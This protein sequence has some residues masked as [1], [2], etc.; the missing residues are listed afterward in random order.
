[1]VSRCI[2]RIRGCSSCCSEG[3]RSIEV[4]ISLWQGV[5]DR[6][7]RLSLVVVEERERRVERRCVDDLLFQEDDGDYF[8]R[9]L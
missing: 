7:R 5:V 8:S 9:L 2:G 4:L 6:R 3:T 1:M